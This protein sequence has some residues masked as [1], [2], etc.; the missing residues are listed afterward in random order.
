[1]GTATT[2]VCPVCL[3]VLPAQRVTINEAVYLDKACPQHGEFSTLVWSDAIDY[4]RW[5]KAAEAGE[6]DEGGP[7]CGSPASDGLPGAGTARTARTDSPPCPTGCGGCTEHNVRVCC[8]LMEVTRRCNLNGPVCFASS[9]GGTPADQDPSL[10]VIASWYD[11][12]YEKAGACHIQ[13]SGG[14][15]TL[16]EDLCQIIRIGRDKGFSYFQLNTNGIRLA[17]DPGLAMRL[18]DAGLTC[19]FLQF[20]GTDDR[21][22]QALRGARLLSLK[23]RTIDACAA[24]RLPVVLVPTVAGGINDEDL[25]AI[26]DYGIQRSPVVR[27]V[28]FQPMSFFGRHTVTATRVTIPELLLA[29]EVQSGGMLSRGHFSGGGVENPHCS[30]NANYVI[31]DEGRL[32]LLGT[33]ASS[34]CGP[35]IEAEPES[36]ASCCEAEP[37][38]SCCEPEPVASCCKPEPAASCCGQTPEDAPES[39]TSCCGQTAENDLVAR[40]QDIQQ[41]RWGTDLDT[42]PAERPEPGTLD[43][44]LWQTRAR[45]FSVTGMAF[46]DAHTQDFERLRSCYIF[47]LDSNGDPIPFCA[48]N[49]TDARGTGPYRG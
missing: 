15:P 37:V 48:Y 36:T 17:E 13:L 20:D 6:T 34:C 46:M 40:A 27:G 19:V 2:S 45:G 49:L 24:A 23:Q 4:A 32:Q 41:R 14:E 47:I 9:E 8:V 12:L 43:E 38:A 35:T 21:I 10:E 11:K 3:R 44:F 22:N 18:K 1:M 29:L 39:V 33:K 7:C 42:L 5:G 31:D 30:F 28:H 16:R 26:I 25:A